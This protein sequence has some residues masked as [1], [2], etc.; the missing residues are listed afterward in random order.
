MKQLCKN[1]YFVFREAVNKEEL[2][3]LLKLRYRVFRNSH[4]ARFVPENQHQLDLDQW[5][6]PSRHFGLFIITNGQSK[7]AGYLR[8]VE[9]NEKPIS[10]VIYSIAEEYSEFSYKVHQTPVIPFPL[11]K[12]FPDSDK[13]QNIYDIIKAKKER[14]VE[15]GRFALESGSRFRQLG[16]HMIESAIAVYFFAKQFENAMWCCKTSQNGFYRRYGFYQLKDGTNSDFAGIGKNAC[17]VLGSINTVP[18]KARPRLTQMAEAYKQTGMICYNPT[19]T[20]CF[21]RIANQTDTTP[22]LKVAVA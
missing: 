14:L 20:S 2:L 10:P 4:L 1:E 5:D 9:N 12:Y 22:K 7:P 11:M 19:N 16:K 6:P 17:C 3:E 21:Y 8:V 18:L 13:I 15:T